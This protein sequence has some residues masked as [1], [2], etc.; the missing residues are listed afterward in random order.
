MNKQDSGS[1]GGAAVAV[2]MILVVLGGFCVIVT[3]AGGFFYLGRSVPPVV[4]APPLPVA[5]VTKAATAFR[6]VEIAVAADGSLTL[7]GKSVALEDVPLQLQQIRAAS[8][9]AQVD[10]QVRPDPA[11]P[12]SAVSKVTDQLSATGFSHTVRPADSA[13][14]SA[15]VPGMGGPAGTSVGEAAATDEAEVV[16]EAT[17]AAPEQERAAEKQDAVEETP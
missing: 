1:G 3:L 5:T 14:A 11:A 16:K 12:Y 17:E 13:E 15:M 10:V 4:V 7:D 2:V 9:N 8:P 6:I